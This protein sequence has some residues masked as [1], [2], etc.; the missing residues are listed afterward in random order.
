MGGLSRSLRMEDLSGKVVIVTG[1]SKG[2]GRAIA[3]RCA[4]LGAMVGANYF[5]SH[6]LAEEL[7]AAHPERI[8]LLKFDVRDRAAVEDAIG[9]FVRDH[10]RID[11]LINNAGIA[12]M[13]LL[14][15]GV[16]RLQVDE[17]IAT[18]LLGPLL[19]SAAVLPKMLRQRDGTIINISSVA[20][21]RPASGQTVYAMTKAAVEA[22]T[23]SITV[24]YAGKGIRALCIRLGPV[25]TDMLRDVDHSNDLERYRSHTAVDRIADPAEV[26]QLVTFLMSCSSRYAAGSC[27]DWDGGYSL[28]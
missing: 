5:R 7:V 17:H 4:E 2:I 8:R 25:D 27:I 26:A 21:V 14:V 16:A 19:C 6:E 3:L 15:K 9:G 18:N 20:A 28:F 1:A 24:E 13:G 23:R 10:G 22:L 12:V 11:T